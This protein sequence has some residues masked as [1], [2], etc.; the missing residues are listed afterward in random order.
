[1]SS[2]LFL[3]SS[4]L[5]E[6]L[7]GRRV[8]QYD[9]LKTDSPLTLCINQVV[10]SEFTYYLMAEEGG[11]SPVTLKRDQRIPAILRE[12]DPTA[13]L[14][15]FIYL[16]TDYRIIPLYLRFMQQYNLLPN[17]AL[18]L[19]TCQLNGITQLA[20]YDADFALACAGEGIQLIQHVG[21]LA[22]KP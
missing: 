1:M 8:D 21:D 20:S 16:D 6:K 19:A 18:I 3:D 13:L 4:I 5:V 17:D 2:R 11:K 15:S 12:N 7:K 14:E 22:Q 10:L 9:Y